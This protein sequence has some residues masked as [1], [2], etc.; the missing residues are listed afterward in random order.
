MYTKN[1]QVK[2]KNILRNLKEVS[3][4]QPIYEAVN[5]SIEA[6]ATHI[7]LALAPDKNT[8]FDD[9]NAND[10]KPLIDRITVTDNG[11]GFT[12]KNIDSF[13]QYYSDFKISLGCKGVGRFTWLKNFT[14]VHISSKIKTETG[15]DVIS[16]LFD[17]DFDQY[18]SK[19]LMDTVKHEE[20]LL[21]ENETT[22]T[23]DGLI[24]NNKR[25]VLD[26]EII[27][28]QVLSHLLPVLTFQ[29]DQK[30]DIVIDIEEENTQN[31]VVIDPS[32]LPVLKTEK[33][34]VTESFTSQKK[35]YDFELK[36][37]FLKDGKKRKQNFYCAHNRAV[38]PFSDAKTETVSFNLP[39]TDSSMMFL[40]SEYFD[41]LVNDS[42]NMFEIISDKPDI[43]APLSWVDINRALKT[44]VTD[45][46]EKAYP[47]IQKENEDKIEQ[48]KA[49]NP[50]LSAYIERNKAGVGAS[51][52][53]DIINKS[54]KEFEADKEKSKQ[55]LSAALKKAK[56]KK[57]Q[58]EDFKQA[59]AHVEYM[60]TLDLAQYIHF[61]QQ[62]IEALKELNDRQETQEELF[63]NMFVQKKFTGVGGAV[64]DS[65]LWL[66]DDKFMTYSY[67]A[68]D[69]EYRKIA[70]E[71]WGRQIEAD[72]DDTRKRPDL[73]IAFSDKEDAAHRDC[74]IVEF[75]AA[76]ASKSEKRKAADEIW[77]NIG[78]VKDNFPTIQHIYGYII[79]DFE[80]AVGKTFERTALFSPVFTRG[81]QKIYFAYNTKLDASCFLI[82]TSCL[83]MDADARNRTFLDV[84]RGNIRKTH[85]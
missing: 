68:S 20:G 31:K 44:H 56:L 84:V 49:D 59:A 33:F 53:A 72:P 66:L 48:L 67:V 28:E 22:I 85:N 35:Q 6:G 41:E 64:L 18:N 76:G 57:S 58:I 51:S 17:K 19:S 15:Y 12:K 62:I 4:M 42:R 29:K 63:H 83:A 46:I 38:S 47:N 27:K 10:V 79:M 1:M 9:S 24:D 40:C 61:R 32:S 26:L 30:K 82:S 75:K 45:M 69:V 80:N 54:K 55:E 39:G 3:F 2:I 77:D 37:S 11:E 16:F 5:N 73:F 7:T 50:H 71:L 36:Y 43:A 8:L 60:A 25:P 14:Q 23:F 21:Q 52:A 78:A 81:E 65:N 70:H 34:S 13:C 74:V